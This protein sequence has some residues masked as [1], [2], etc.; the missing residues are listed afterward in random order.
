MH[1]YISVISKILEF[2][3][4]VA[5]VMFAS[6]KSYTVCRNNK[7]VKF[8]GPLNLEYQF[9]YIKELLRKLTE[10]S[11]N[12]RGIFNTDLYCKRIIV[13]SN[14]LLQDSP[15]DKVWAVLV[16]TVNIKDELEVISFF[17]N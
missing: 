11:L 8:K 15:C 7:V 14:I 10:S 9:A 3:V 16:C 17:Y 13:T 12:S 6:H 1:V 5:A 2:R 4:N